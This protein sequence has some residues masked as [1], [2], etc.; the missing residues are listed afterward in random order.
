MRSLYLTAILA[1]LVAACDPVTVQQ[2]T[3]SSATV[4]A[5]VH[6]VQAYTVKACAFEPIAA[7]VIKLFNVAAGMTIEAVGGAIC[8]AATSIP[9][10][11]GGTRKIVVNGVQ[12]K[13]RRIVSVLR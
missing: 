2:A 5:A 6:Q 1:A 7:S 10:A 4:V 3:Q 13:G 11:D 12:I 8:N 9:L